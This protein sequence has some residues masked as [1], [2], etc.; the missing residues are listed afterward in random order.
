MDIRDCWCDPAGSFSDLSCYYCRGERAVKFK[1]MGFSTRAANLLVI[2]RC[3]TPE[4]FFKRF[5]P[6]YVLRQPNMGKH[7]VNELKRYAQKHGIAWGDPLRL[8]Y[9]ASGQSEEITYSNW[10]QIGGKISNLVGDVESIAV[11]ENGRRVLF[12]HIDGIY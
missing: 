10:A 2:S 11:F 9:F 3:E 4:D 12:Y 8:V 5:K 1:A 7:T 6:A